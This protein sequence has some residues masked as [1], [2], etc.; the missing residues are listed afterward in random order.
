NGTSVVALNDGHGVFTRVTTGSW[1]S[2]EVHETVDI[3]GDG[4]VDL[5]ATFQDGGSQW[6]INNSTP[7]H[8]NFVAT[9]VTRSTNTSRTQAMV[10][11]NGDGKVDWFRS[12]PPGLVV[13]FGDG[14]GNFTEGSLSFA[15]PNTDSNNNASFLPG[16]FDGDGKID[17]L[18]ITGGAYDGT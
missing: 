5:N 18:V 11:F 8:V 7:G 10:D 3:N 17:L 16:D 2:T 9:A 13:D 4:K 1:P 15:I 6:W 12:A 14:K